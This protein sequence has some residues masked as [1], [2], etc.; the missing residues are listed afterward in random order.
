MKREIIRI[1][2]DLC[3][4]CGICIPNCHEGA[5]QIVDGK[6]RLIS[7]LMCDGL[8]A[9]IGHCPE[10]AITM[11][12]R[13]AVP[14]SEKTVMEEMISKGKNTIIAHLKHLKD[15]KEFGFLKE[16][17]EYLL[18]NRE[19]A[20]FDVDDVLE[21]VHTHKAGGSEK[22]EAKAPQQQH[23][24][25]GHANTHAHAHAHPHPQGGGGCPGSR[26][27]TI[28][29]DNLSL[30]GGVASADAP[31]ELRQWPVQMH[32]INPAAG[33]FHGSDVV[34]AADCVAFAAGNFHNKYLKG[35]TVAIAC[36]KLDSNMEVYVSKITSLIDDSKVNT[37]TVIMMEVPCCGGLLRLV[38]AGAE[39]ATRKVPLKMII[40][41]INGEPVK[42]EWVS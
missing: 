24:G 7:D 5:L 12:T 35:K 1:D 23:L 4:G 40:I 29:R 19:N 42:E 17:V 30:A 28:E 25:H 16:G 38:K 32:L 36:P 31:S 6:A 8:G 13:E 2:E 10:G 3:N 22:P 27:M 18:A 41:G 11:E 37:V 15:H 33:Y 14:Y 21:T 34:I 9:C 39:K 26:S 20:G